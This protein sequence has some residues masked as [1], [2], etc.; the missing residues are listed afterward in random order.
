MKILTNM[1]LSLFFSFIIIAND[2]THDNTMCKH[3]PKCHCQA[4][5]RVYGNYI[6]QS[7]ASR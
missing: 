5:A 7:S 2:S 3:G 6:Y 1:F 4:C